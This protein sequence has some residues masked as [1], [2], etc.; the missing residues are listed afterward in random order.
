MIAIAT[1]DIVVAADALV[2]PLA[3][4]RV[5]LGL[6]RSPWTI[7]INAFRRSVLFMID[8]ALLLLALIAASA[9]VKLGNA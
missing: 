7:P 5:R 8:V 1:I 4:L 6:R 2:K 9:A 3:A